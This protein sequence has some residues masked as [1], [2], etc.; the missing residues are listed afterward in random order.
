MSIFN[1]LSFP[2]IEQDRFDKIMTN[3]YKEQIT[4][5]SSCESRGCIKTNQTKR[6]MQRLSSLYISVFFH[7]M[8]NLCVEAEISLRV[9]ISINY[10]QLQFRNNFSDK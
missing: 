3:S 1:K 6:F 4:Y 7:R 9:H 10:N 2:I 8:K 5:S